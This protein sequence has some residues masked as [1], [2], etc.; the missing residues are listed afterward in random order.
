M[1]FFLRFGYD[2]SFLTPNN[3]SGKTQILDLHGMQSQ[4]E[5]IGISK[6]SQRE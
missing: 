2:F 3:K 1:I 5:S 6:P 4:H